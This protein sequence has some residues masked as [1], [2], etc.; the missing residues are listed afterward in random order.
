MA[1][2]VEDK[3]D[4]PAGFLIPDM[5]G[6]PGCAVVAGPKT[7]RMVA[8]YFDTPDLRLASRGITLRRRRG[9]DDAGWH[10][11]LPKAKGAREEIGVPLTRSA[12][13]VPPEIAD[14]VLAYSRREPLVPVAELATRREVTVLRDADGRPLIEIADDT[15]KGTVYGDVWGGARR[16]ERWREVEAEIKDGDTGHLKRTGKALRKAGATPAASG[17]KLGRLLGDA[18]PVSPLAEPAGGTAGRV[19][20][21]YLKS[22]VDALTAQDPQVRREGYDAVHQMRVASRRLRSAMKSFGG[23]VAG[24]DEIQEELRWI[25]AVLGEARDLEVI[26]ERFGTLLRSVPAGLVVGPIRVRLDDD[27]LARHREALVRVDEAMRGERYFALLDRLDALVANPPLTPLAMKQADKVLGKVAVKSWGRVVRRY[28]IAQSTADPCERE[29]AM[30][31]VRK[32]AKRARY[33]AESLKSLL[34]DR[35]TA[36]ARR[37]KTVQEVLGVH[38][39]G[40]VAQEILVEEAARARAAGEDTFTYGVLV[41]LEHAEA[42]RSHEDF[43]RVWAEAQ[44]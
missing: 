23:V 34:G 36:M 9:G 3:F 26:H 5:S 19:V 30:H 43:P 12:T 41:G 27:L 32:A 15:V 17:S 37:A 14:M 7:Y 21:D 20:V 22:Q 6:V 39:D 4:V 44:I 31:D 38:Q 13:V 2:E 29:I 16:V 40:V 25:A 42:K 35:A 28:D 1:L 8:V 33:T 10:L 11:K 24:T 18:V